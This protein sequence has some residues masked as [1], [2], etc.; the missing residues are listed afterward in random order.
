[1]IATP[2]LIA[3]ADGFG[4][5]D[6]VAAAALAAFATGGLDSAVALAASG[7]S[8]ALPGQ[9][10]SGTTLTGVEIEGGTA[11]ITHIGDARV[12]LVRDRE[13]RQVTHDHT[14]VAGLL[15]AGHLTADEA[16]SHEHRNLLN[17]ALAPGVVPDEHVLD[18]RPGI[19]S[20]SPRTVSTPGSRTSVR[21]SSRSVPPQEVADLV[22]D[23]VIEAGEPDNHTIVVVD[24]SS[25]RE[26]SVA[27][28]VPVAPPSLGW[29][30]AGRGQSRS[31]SLV[32]EG[33]SPVT[34]PG[35]LASLVEEGRSPV[36]RPGGLAS[37]VEEGRSPVTRPGGFASLV[38]EGRV[39]SRDRRIGWVEGG[40]AVLGRVG[41]GGR[42]GWSTR[43]PRVRP[44]GSAR[45]VWVLSRWWNRHN[46]ARFAVLVGP[47]WGLPSCRCRRCG[48]TR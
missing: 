34:R 28:D 47:G 15:E 20:C 18:L 38:E 40:G 17:R 32:E 1:M 5:R 19:A 13:V 48:R 44:S 16:R 45:L 41:S 43:R 27:V 7:V 29:R 36:T 21:C 26:R 11:R 22:A 37:L 9:P 3:V 23:A 42:G 46:A 30:G 31:D 10:T 12:W 39:L 33:R 25:I 6:D 14:I 2:E 4:D 8:A 24:L 35:G